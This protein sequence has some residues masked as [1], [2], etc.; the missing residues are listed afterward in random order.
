MGRAL[1]GFDPRRGGPTRVVVALHADTSTRTA[2]FLIKPQVSGSGRSNLAGS[3]PAPSGGQIA[4]IGR[5][6]APILASSD[7]TPEVRSRQAGGL[8]PLTQASWGIARPA[9]AIVRCRD[10]TSAAVAHAMRC[11]CWS[12]PTAHA[13]P[14]TAIPVRV[15][16]LRD[17]ITAPLRWQHGR[18]PAGRGVSPATIHGVRTRSSLLVAGR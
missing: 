3:V 13:C 4:K 12:T 15:Q 10:M 11:L 1:G 7:D 8:A 9:V 5:A 17:R 14:S 6:Q 16:G 18:G 2:G